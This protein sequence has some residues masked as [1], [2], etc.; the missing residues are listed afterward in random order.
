MPGETGYVN[1]LPIWKGVNPF[2]IA[3]LEL[4]WNSR[5]RIPKAYKNLE[6]VSVSVSILRL[7][8]V[9]VSISRLEEKGL[10]LGLEVE[11]LRKK[12]SVSVS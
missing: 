9:S 3:H 4:A 2:Y 5:E 1:N 8:A 12:I 11:I 6:K 10:N 7:I